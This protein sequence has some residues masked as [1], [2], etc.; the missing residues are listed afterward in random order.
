M[1]PLYRAEQ[2]RQLDQQ[3]IEEFGISGV[4][5]MENA[6]RGAADICERY[7][8]QDLRAGDGSI[9]ILAGPGN[10]GGDG[11]V[12]ARHLQ[13]HGYRV[14]VYLCAEEEKVRGD[15]AINLAIWRKMGGSI[16][17]CLEEAQLE[18]AVARFAYSSMIVDALLGTG[19]SRPVEGWLLRV[20]EALTPLT[21]P[22]LVAVDLPSGM[23]ADTGHPM[24]LCFR[25]DATVTFA[26]RKVGLSMPHALEFVGQEHLVDIGAPQALID[27]NT[28]CCEL[29]DI[30][31]LKLFWRPR[32][33]NTHKGSYGHVLVVAG[34][35]GKV[36]AALLS[37]LAVLRMGAGLCTLASHNAV[38]EAVEGRIFEVMTERL[39]VGAVDARTSYSEEACARAVSLASQRDAMVI[40]PGLGQDLAAGD[41]LRALLDVEC[42]AVIDADGLNLLVGDLESL[43]K[44]KAPTIL[45]P[46]PGEMARLCGCS[47]RDVQNDRLTK[48]LDIAKR[49]QCVVVLKG[50]RTLIATPTGRC[51]MNPTGHAGMATAGSGDVL[52]G[53]LGALLAQGYSVEESACLGVFWHGLAGDHWAKEKAMA[54]LV[55]SDLLDA[56]PWILKDWELQLAQR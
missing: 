5:L 48:A 24:P 8:Q 38:V 47:T 15:A 55:A 41:L 10:N 13:N 32:G 45:T 18:E 34:A 31:S 53:M 42:P 50:A 3:A 56:L 46:H 1:K 12:I 51:W 36:G 44:R 37:S 17:P 39:F 20:L 28:P 52:A 14:E 43:Q 27:A 40:G 35:P 4:V 21:S 7:L 19:L 23:H 49:S 6:G 30:A 33:T 16:H 26:M 54:T 25:A 2:V 9:C 22:W 29:L 11:F